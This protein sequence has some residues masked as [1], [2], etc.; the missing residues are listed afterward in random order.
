VGRFDGTSYTGIGAVNTNHTCVI[1]ISTAPVTTSTL[2]E[3]VGDERRGGFQIE[4]FYHNTQTDEVGAPAVLVIGHPHIVVPE[5]EGREPLYFASIN[6]AWDPNDL[7]HSWTCD[8][9][10]LATGD[11]WI[12]MPQMIGSDTE[13]IEHRGITAFRLH[14][15]LGDDPAW[16]PKRLDMAE[17]AYEAMRRQQSI[18]GEIALVR[19]NYMVPSVVTQQ[20][21]KAGT[22]TVDFTLDGKYI[23]I[24]NSYPFEFQWDSR[25]VPNGEYVLRADVSDLSGKEID[26][27][28]RCI[29]VDN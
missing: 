8:V 17:K 29:Y 4:P 1:T 11:S 21:M 10:T 6:L 24:T 18:N 15:D 3:G 14:R 27:I 28:V 22:P 9:Q 13:A 25:S 2:L 19:G 5:L 23:G 7:A 26:S 16:L 12:P 20:D